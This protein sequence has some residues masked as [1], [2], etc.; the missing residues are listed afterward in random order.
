MV[1]TQLLWVSDRGDVAEQAED[2]NDVI[3]CSYELYVCCDGCLF[4]GFLAHEC[5]IGRRKR[6]SSDTLPRPGF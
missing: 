3:R 6:R 2:S 5:P 1:R 4:V